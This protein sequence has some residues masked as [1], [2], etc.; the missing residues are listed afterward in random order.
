MQTTRQLIQR[1]HVQ[2]L[3]FALAFLT[4]MMNWEPV[5]QAIG[6]SSSSARVI[7][8]SVKYD[9]LAQWYKITMRP[10]PSYGPM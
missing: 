4:I 7:I 8:S 6:D 5:L 1:D 10:D 3:F 9:V 2:S